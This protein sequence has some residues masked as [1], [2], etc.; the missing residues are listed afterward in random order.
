MI[1][2]TAYNCHPFFR[3]KTEAYQTS[4]SVSEAKTL[5]P[6][7]EKVSLDCFTNRPNKLKCRWVKTGKSYPKMEMQWTVVESY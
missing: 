3:F 1:S 7:E 4:S 5:S 2:S 6:L